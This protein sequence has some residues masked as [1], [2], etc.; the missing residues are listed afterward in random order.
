MT[1]I[2]KRK[3]LDET[4]KVIRDYL[5]S[6]GWKSVDDPMNDNWGRIECPIAGSMHD[7]DHA[8][9]LQLERNRIKLINSE[10]K[11][12]TKIENK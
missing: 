3:L 10:Y 5:H 11:E 6:E 12:T 8:Y 2:K 7:L 4:L 1:Y 9:T